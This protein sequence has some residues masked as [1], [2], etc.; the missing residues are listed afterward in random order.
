[1]KPIGLKALARPWMGPLLA[2]IVLYVVFAIMTDGGFLRGVTQVTIARQTVVVALGAVGMTLVIVSGGIDLS[3]GSVVALCAV[4]VARAL[5]AGYG[6]L[7][8][9]ALGVSVGLACG[10][11]N[12]ALVAALKIT[13]FI[14]TLGTMSAL[15]GLAKGLANE[16]KIDAEPQ[17]LEDLMA[18]VPGGGGF[19]FPGGVWIA[20]ALTVAVAIVLERARFGRHVI[21]VGSSPP[22]ARLAGISVGRVTLG[23]YLVAG[24]LAGVAGVMDFATL[25]VGDPTGSVGLE[26]SV[27]AAVVIGGGSLAG[28]Q[29]SIAGSLV[30]A[31][32][33]TV[34]AAG[35]TQLGIANWVQE[36][37]TGAIIVVA[38]ALDR[39]RHR[40]S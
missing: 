27:I 35:A 36:I 37:L 14:V 22:A 33:M 21:A 15:R 9:V 2:L 26:L 1:M 8:A 5:D 3:I 13:P 20:I 11:L 16:Q 25:T 7:T 34:L 28:G 40:I 30:G 4:V 24:A 6:P 19:L 12:G 38:V 39:L 23:A 10:A 18:M 29:G 17:G 31:L 32:L